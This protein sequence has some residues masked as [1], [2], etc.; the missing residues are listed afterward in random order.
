MI[1][2]VAHTSGC[3][4]FDF[5]RSMP[6][7]VDAITGCLNLTRLV[8]FAALCIILFDMIAV[9]TGANRCAVLDL[10]RAVTTAVDAIT[11][12]WLYL[13][14]FVRFAGRRF[15]LFNMIARLAAANGCAVF[16]LTRTVLAAGHA[17]ACI[18][19]TVT[20]TTIITTR[21]HKG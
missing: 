15:I 13:P 5:A 4:V 21:G 19:V 11:S 9:V 2:I 6:T 18:I 3:A 1:A 17:S 16:D 20:V 14:R 12:N 7:A 8:R 10:T